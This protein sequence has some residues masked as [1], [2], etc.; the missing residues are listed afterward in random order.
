MAE[1]QVRNGRQFPVFSKAYGR[2]MAHEFFSVSAL[3]S[4]QGPHDQHWKAKRHGLRA[5][6]AARL[7]YQKGRPA[8]ERG[9]VT[10]I[11]HDSQGVIESFPLVSQAALH[12]MIHACHHCNAES[13]PA[14][15]QGA[16]RACAR[17][18]AAAAPGDEQARDCAGGAVCGRGVRKILPDGNSE[19][20]DVFFRHTHVA[21]AFGRGV[22]WRGIP[23]VEVVDP[24]AVRAVVRDNAPYRKACAAAARVCAH[25]GERVGLCAHHCVRG[26]ALHQI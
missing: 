10:R 3:L 26:E 4:W 6:Q 5:G 21:E 8:H 11:R 12:C 16:Q 7:S 2:A 25:D 17:S 18:Q 23:A 24:E 19:N 9:H 15:V 20:A 1:Q 22:V 13:R 14:A